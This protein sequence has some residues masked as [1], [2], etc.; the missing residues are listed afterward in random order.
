MVGRKL[1]I[2][3]YFY[4][5]GYIDKKLVAHEQCG[6]RDADSLRAFTLS[7]PVEC[8]HFVTASFVTKIN[9]A[10]LSNEY[11]GPRIFPDI[12]QNRT[13]LFILVRHFA[14]FLPKNLT[15]LCTNL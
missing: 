5:I 2:G 12:Q 3:V 6:V 7:I 10:L 15:P 9:T 4:R 8:Q 13:D 11:H 1:P 14:D